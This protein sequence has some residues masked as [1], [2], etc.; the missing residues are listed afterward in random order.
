MTPKSQLHSPIPTLSLGSNSNSD[1]LVPP[2]QKNLP[3]LKLDNAAK[4]VTLLSTIA[5]LTQNRAMSKEL[6]Q[7]ALYNLRDQGLLPGFVQPLEDQA[8]LILQE[9]QELGRCV[10]VLQCNLAGRL[11]DATQ[12]GLLVD[13]SSSVDHN[14][15]T[16][17]NTPNAI[18]KSSSDEHLILQAYSPI[19]ALE[20]A[21]QLYIDPQTDALLDAAISQLE[22]HI[23][24]RVK[25]GKGRHSDPSGDSAS[26]LLQVPSRNRDMSRGRKTM[27]PKAIFPALRN[28]KEI[29]NF[30]G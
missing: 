23:Q 30:R 20:A 25:Q 1:G 19:V 15:D 4:A 11:D 10:T 28:P 21:I 18:E 12:D 14:S 22:K 27:R 26:V 3:N 6:C 29:D 5:G 24:V 13:G 16:G 8:E 7:A 17:A 2:P 9:F